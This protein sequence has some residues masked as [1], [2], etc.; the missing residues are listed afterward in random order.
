MPPAWFEMVWTP[1]NA[2][3][4]YGKQSGTETVFSPCQYHTN[5]ALCSYFINVPPVCLIFQTGCWHVK[6]IM[7]GLWKAT[8]LVAVTLKKD[9]P[10][11]TH[12]RPTQY[13]LNPPR[14]A[15]VPTCIEKR[16]KGI[17]LTK[18]P[19]FTSTTFVWLLFIRV[20]ILYYIILYSYVETAF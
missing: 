16:G 17:E 10:T 9:W 6:V 5:T 4:I 19:S 18:T 12:W 7:N 8:I 1:F 2:S 13:V 3:G 14:A 11:S 20:A 15:L